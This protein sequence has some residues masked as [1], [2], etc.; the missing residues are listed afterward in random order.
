MA[1]EQRTL[2][3]RKRRLSNNEIVFY[4]IMGMFCLLFISGF[5]LG[6]FTS[7]EK[8]ETVTE[9]KYVPVV[10][11]NFYYPTEKEYI[12]CDETAELEL[13]YHYELPLSDDLQDYIFELCSEENVPV[14]LVL[15]MISTESGFQPEVISDTDD[16]GLMQI[17]KCNHEWLKETY[18]VSDFLDPY[19][20]VYCGIKIIGQLLDK[21]GD[22]NKALMAYNMGEERAKTLWEQGVVS[23]SYSR[24]IVTNMAIYEEGTNDSDD[25]N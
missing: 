6:R 2:R 9:I 18:D 20:N 21:Y 11:N 13:T 16:Y 3:K 7:P 22:Y 14:S 8:V 5:L 19:E 12:A 1:T 10:R 24:E 17:N 4:R 15:S 25:Q 23:S